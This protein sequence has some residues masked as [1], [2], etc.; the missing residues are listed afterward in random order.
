MSPSST[1]SQTALALVGAM[2]RS[3][4]ALSKELERALGA[5]QLT[6][7]QFAVLEMLG[8]R[9]PLPLHR[10]GEELGVSGGNVTCVIDNLAK[11][12]LVVRQRDTQ[13]RRVFQASLTPAG[14]ARLA[15]AQPVYQARAVALTAGLTDMEQGILVQLLQKLALTLTR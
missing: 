13:D 10:I 3:H 8:R 4:G 15:T 2:A 12:D 1:D 7:P 5:H 14:A 11:L 6:T 9:G